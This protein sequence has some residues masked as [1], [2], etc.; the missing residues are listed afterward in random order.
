MPTTYT[1]TVKTLRPE[2][3]A[4]LRRIHDDPRAD[5]SVSRLAL[6]RRLGLARY[7]EPPRSPRES[8]AS[9][10]APPRRGHVLTALGEQQIDAGPPPPPDLAQV[11]KILR[12]GE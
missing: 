9:R 12:G 8:G 5:V 4:D 11:A 3:L 6:F 2:H 1:V 10:K 7:G